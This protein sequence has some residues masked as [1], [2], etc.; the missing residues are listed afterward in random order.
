MVDLALYH[1]DIQACKFMNMSRPCV[2]LKLLLSTTSSTQLSNTRLRNQ[3]VLTAFSN[4]LSDFESHLHRPG[5]STMHALFFGV[6]LWDP[7]F[8]PI[9]RLGTVTLMHVMNSDAQPLHRPLHPRHPKF[10]HRPP[11]LLAPRHGHVM[12]A[13]CPQRGP[14]AFPEHWR[15][16]LANSPSPFHL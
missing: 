1:T 8:M 3:A 15:C 11:H 14:P 4:S 6:A 5:I 2:L 7:R 12:R 10:L 16:L 9:H 13:P